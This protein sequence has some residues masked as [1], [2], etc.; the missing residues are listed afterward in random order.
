MTSIVLAKFQNCASTY[1][2]TEAVIDDIRGRNNIKSYTFKNI[3]YLFNEETKTALVLKCIARTTTKA[4]CKK[5]YKK[6]KIVFDIGKRCTTVSNGVAAI[7]HFFSIFAGYDLVIACGSLD[8]E[9]C[10]FFRQD[11]KGKLEAI[12]FN[13]NY[14]VEQDGVESSRV[15]KALFISLKKKLIKKQSFYAGCGNTG[16]LCSAFTWER[17]H[18]HVC[19]GLTPFNDDGLILEDYWHNTTASSHHRYQQNR[20]ALKAETKPLIHYEV[21][22]PFDLKLEN[23]DAREIFGIAVEISKMVAD[24]HIDE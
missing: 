19:D 8:H 10:V 7:R 20:K 3:E 2:A 15:V 11:D 4:F 1:Q 16:G 5:S 21:W 14:S 23:V 17:I 9:C 18:Q 12:Y 13:P 6:T 22:K 24:L